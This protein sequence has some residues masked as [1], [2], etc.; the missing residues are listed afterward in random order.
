MKDLENIVVSSVGNFGDISAEVAELSSLG[1]ITLLSR[2]IS[3]DATGFIIICISLGMSLVPLV[4]SFTIRTRDLIVPKIPGVTDATPPP[5]SASPATT[6]PVQTVASPDAASQAP[7]LGAAHARTD[8]TTTKGKLLF[9]WRW[10]MLRLRYLVRTPT[11]FNTVLH[12]LLILVMYNL[13]TYPITVLVGTEDN[14]T[15]SSSYEETIDNYCGGTLINLIEQ[16]A[17]VM[18]TYLVSSFMYLAVLVR[19]PPRIY[20]NFALPVLSVVTAASALAVLFL[21]NTIPGIATKIVVAVAQVL[22]YYINAFTYYVM[23]TAIRQEYYGVIMA[24]YAFGV[25]SILAGTS[26]V[27]YLAIPMELL[28]WVCIGLIVV[29]TIHGFWMRRLFV[30][31]NWASA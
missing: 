27:L 16:G 15:H 5:G 13:F 6:N 20:Y 4:L 1:A 8:T 23:N 9:A 2:F 31:P 24:V 12:S 29:C 22:P 30:N 10:L 21:R 18:A 19:C 14:E 7:L 28:V 3:A 26:A 25:Q 11:V 17:I